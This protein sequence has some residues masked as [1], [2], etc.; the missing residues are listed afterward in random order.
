MGTIDDDPATIRP[1]L[2]E[3]HDNDSE[4]CWWK[5]DRGRGF[6][7]VCCCCCCCCC[8]W[9]VLYG[10]VP[11]QTVTYRTIAS[12]HILPVAD[13]AANDVAVAVDDNDDPAT[14]CYQ[15]PVLYRIYCIQWVCRYCY[16]YQI[17][18]ISS[19]V[20]CTVGPILSF[21]ICCFCIY[22][23]YHC[24]QSKKIIVVSSIVS[25]PV[26]SVADRI[27]DDGICCV[28]R[29]LLQLLCHQYSSSFSSSCAVH[30]DITPW[31][32]IYCH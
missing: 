27:V 5:N 3:I 16:C 2:H 29:W 21:A 12:H 15:L 7:F 1:N 8:C 24:R 25:D 4:S 9:L 6:F 20:G 17:T 26:V 13:V 11:Y 28:H 32:F 18:N 14:V 31:C 10:T 23:Y 22:L 30:Y 19:L